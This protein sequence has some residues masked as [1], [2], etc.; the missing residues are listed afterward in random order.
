MSQERGHATWRWEGG[1][2][3]IRTLWFDQPETPQNFL[4][5]SAFEGLEAR[6]VELENDS[7]ARGLVLRS[8]K[9]AGFSGPICKRSCPAVRLEECESYV[10]SGPRVLD[11]LH[12]SLYRQSP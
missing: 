7:S 3:G 11:H 8:T 9:A 5:L 12:R 10:M 4:D 2:G 1:S 6:L